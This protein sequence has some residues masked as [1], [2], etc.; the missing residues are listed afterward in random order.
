MCG[1]LG[2]F[3]TEGL[4]EQLIKQRQRLQ[5]VF[6]TSQVGRGFSFTRNHAEE[7]SDENRKSKVTTMISRTCSGQ[8]L[9]KLKDIQSHNETV[10]RHQKLIWKHYL[11][12][13]MNLIGHKNL[14]SHGEVFSFPYKNSELDCNLFTVLGT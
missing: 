12:S 6:K 3:I 5:K 4:Y 14:I 11:N 9:L 1:V 2:K 10:K 7:S 13:N 8:R